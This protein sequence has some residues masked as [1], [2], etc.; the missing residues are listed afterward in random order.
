[1]PFLSESI[2]DPRQLRASATTLA[3]HHVLIRPLALPVVPRT[4]VRHRVRM[5]AICMPA[6][7]REAAEAI[8]A[9]AVRADDVW[10]L[11]Y[12]GSGTEAVQQL[13]VRLLGGAEAE[14][15]ADEEEEASRAP[16]LE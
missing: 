5:R 8:R 9:T 3:T 7:Y 2:T 6:A 12:P 1:M 14:V 4:D 13:V 16:L 15:G 10:V 11:G